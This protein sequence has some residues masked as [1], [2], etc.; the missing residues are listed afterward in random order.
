MPVFHILVLC[1]FLASA[2]SGGNPLQD[3]NLVAK[4]DTGLALIRKAGKIY[5]DTL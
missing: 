1:F 2:V 4:P 3:L 5:K